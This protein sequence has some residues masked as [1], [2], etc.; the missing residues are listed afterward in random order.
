[1][2]TI[3]HN[4]CMYYK[5]YGEIVLYRRTFEE[6]EKFLDN[7]DVKDKKT[8]P[9]LRTQLIRFKAYLNMEKDSW[10]K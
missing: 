9:Y 7:N 5:P 3:N 10:I 2:V 6:I 4:D 8:I 1:M